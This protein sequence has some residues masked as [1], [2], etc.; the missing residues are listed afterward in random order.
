[1]YASFI[2]RRQFARSLLPWFLVCFGPV[3]RLHVHHVWLICL[4]PCVLL[5]YPMLRTLF[6]TI[7]PLYVEYRLFCITITVIFA[8]TSNPALKTPSS[9]KTMPFS[10]LTYEPGV[11]CFL[12]HCS[13]SC[14][15]ICNPLYPRVQPS[16]LR[17]DS[18]SPLGP[19]PAVLLIALPGPR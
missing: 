2:V 19:L 14:P 10:M 7:L 9:H 5:S 16:S 4:Y 17:V 3:L 13:L 8:S 15:C 18:R 1:M 6:P 11:Y 12:Q